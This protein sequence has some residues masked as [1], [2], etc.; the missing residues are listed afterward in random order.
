V[1]PPDLLYELHECHSEKLRPLS[2]DDLHVARP[3]LLAGARVGKGDSFRPLPQG[4]A[5]GCLWGAKMS[6]VSRRLTP[7]PFGSALSLLGGP[8]TAM[9]TTS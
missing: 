7:E 9:A 6:S 8:P 5:V 4:A 2:H 3:I 1:S